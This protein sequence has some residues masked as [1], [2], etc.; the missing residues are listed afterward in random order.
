[1]NNNLAQIGLTPEQA[2]YWYVL[3]LDQTPNSVFSIDY[4]LRFSGTTYEQRFRQLI[5]LAH[6]LTRAEMMFLRPKHPKSYYI[7]LK[8]HHSHNKER[9]FYGTPAI[10]QFEND[11]Y[12][13]DDDAKWSSETEGSYYSGNETKNIPNNYQRREKNYKGISR[14]PETYPS[15]YFKDYDRVY[16]IC[17]VKTVLFL[18]RTYKDKQIA[19]K[20]FSW[21]RRILRL[22]PMSITEDDLEDLKTDSLQVM[23]QHDLRKAQSSSA[24]KRKKESSSKRIGV[25]SKTKNTTKTKT[26]SKKTNK[27]DSDIFEEL[28]DLSYR[29]RDDQSQEDKNEQKEPFRYGTEDDRY[30]NVS[31]DLSRKESLKPEK[32]EENTNSSKVLIK[33]PEKEPQLSIPTAT[34]ISSSTTNAL[35]KTST[36]QLTNIPEPEINLDQE[37]STTSENQATGNITSDV[38]LEITK[39]A[40]ATKSR[41]KPILPLQSKLKS[42]TYKVSKNPHTPKKSRQAKRAAQRSIREEI[43]EI[44]DYQDEVF[45]D[46]Y[47]HD[48]QPSHSTTNTTTDV[49]KTIEPK[50]RTFRFQAGTDEFVSNH[51]GQNFFSKQKKEE[52]EELQNSPTLS[53]INSNL[54]SITDR[55]SSQIKNSPILSKAI[56]NP[57]PKPISN[58][59]ITI[60]RE[61]IEQ[62][63]REEEYDD[64]D[65]MVYIDK[66]DIYTIRNSN[67]SLKPNDELFSSSKTLAVASSNTLIDSKTHL[68]NSLKDSGNANDDLIQLNNTTSTNS[69]SSSQDYFEISDDDEVVF[70][71]QEKIY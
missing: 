29:M 5:K 66:S 16:N 45:L 23:V 63:Q 10:S 27:K 4:N 60:K 64:D 26:R 53:S 49:E 33:E 56:K 41:V 11:H 37:L 15:E 1:M 58:D 17:F 34:S 44:L 55:I 65:D 51:S 46:D 50:E 6:S 52:G 70:V 54:E 9:E 59:P 8:K 40:K 12:E 47:S 43:R 14:D 42:D 68:L 48:D 18:L 19:F 67:N 7:Y 39:A 25:P 21:Y 71:K 3:K 62:Q 30:Y 20:P 32:T 36:E 24:K 31:Y 57:T 2:P 69:N 28:S 61:N 22:K 38:Q 13:R 35:S